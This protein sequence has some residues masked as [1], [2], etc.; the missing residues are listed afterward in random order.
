MT[1]ILYFLRVSPHSEMP[2]GSKFSEASVVHRNRGFRA[3]HGV[4]RW[5][6][7]VEKSKF[8]CYHKKKKE[9]QEELKTVV[10]KNE[11]Y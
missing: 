3:T 7:L 8:L 11:A 9:L 10:Q 5:V 2:D 6:T 1:A 4:M